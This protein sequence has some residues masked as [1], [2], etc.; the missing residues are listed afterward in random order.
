MN[1]RIGC[2]VGAEH[3]RI[4]PRSDAEGVR[5]ESA[6]R[7]DADR[8]E[9]GVQEVTSS[10]RSN[11]CD[12]PSSDSDLPDLMNPKKTEEKKKKASPKKKKSKAEKKREDPKLMK[13]S[14]KLF[15]HHQ[16]QFRSVSKDVASKTDKI[17]K[18]KGLAESRVTNAGDSSE[19]NSMD[20]ESGIVI[21]SCH[22]LAE[23]NPDHTVQSPP[24]EHM[25][26]L[27]TSLSPPVPASEP[28][29]SK[30]ST[31][32]KATLTTSVMPPTSPDEE[33]ILKKI[34]ANMAKSLIKCNLKTMVRATDIPVQT[35]N[36][37]SDS[38][39]S[40]IQQQGETPSESNLQDMPSVT[41]IPE[42]ATQVGNNCPQ[43]G[44]HQQEKLPNISRL[45]NIVTASEI[46]VES[47]NVSGDSPEPGTH[48]QEKT[49]NV[50]MEPIHLC[51]ESEDENEDLH[52][53]Y[54]SDGNESVDSD[55]TVLFESRSADDDL[56]VETGRKKKN[57]HGSDMPPAEEINTNVIQ[58]KA[59]EKTSQEQ[60][61]EHD[62]LSQNRGNSKRKPEDLLEDLPVKRIKKEIISSPEER[63]PMVMIPLLPN[64][65]ASP[66]SDALSCTSSVIN[67]GG[68]IT[69]SIAPNTTESPL[70]TAAPSLPNNTNR[71]ASSTMVDDPGDINSFRPTQNTTRKL[72]PLSRVIQKQTPAQEPA[73]HSVP[74]G[75]PPPGP[76]NAGIG[77]PP[78]PETG[79][80]HQKGL[81]LSKGVMEEIEKDMRIILGED[82]TDE[83]DSLQDKDHT[84]V[85]HD[86]ETEMEVLEGTPQLNISAPAPHV[87]ETTKFKA[88]ESTTAHQTTKKCS[89][90]NNEET[91]LSTGIKNLMVLVNKKKKCDE[92]IERLKSIMEKKISILEAKKKKLEKKINLEL[93]QMNEGVVSL[94]SEDDDNSEKSDAEDMVSDIGELV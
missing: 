23:S 74:S 64:T 75:S 2:A 65:S 50:D 17:K 29:P 51:D 76:C 46:P 54:D 44:I 88:K 16:K 77:A 60:L 27:T 56:D 63:Q 41:E 93:T 92:K 12:S 13:K 36:A 94:T 40:G 11:V 19:V 68:I 90:P 52:L 80:D 10:K 4:I 30:S 38:P 7:L 70:L 24:S 83:H 58:A 47:A 45:Q 42:Q 61:T 55:K 5:T 26:S 35:A 21:V 69:I 79:K 91:K 82:N 57:G 81:K 28:P 86:D 89:E 22:S 3:P 72:P 71:D 33:E 9:E 87:A 73:P 43:P 66:P 15:K 49:A 32:S 8:A 62:E 85:N 34:K 14:K 39:Q 78:E 1:I 67:S 31:L 25:P 18:P 6:K 37:T 59:T 48:Q 20:M 53:A 84:E